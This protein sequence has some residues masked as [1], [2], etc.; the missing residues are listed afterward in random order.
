MTKVTGLPIRLCNARGIRVLSV[1]AQLSLALSATNC[2]TYASDRSAV[3]LPA[4][5]FDSLIEN[6]RI[7]TLPQDSSKGA[8]APLAGFTAGSRLVLLYGKSPSVR[9]FDASTGTLEVATGKPGDSPG[10]YRKPN[11]IAPWSNGGFVVYDDGRRRL[12]FRDSLGVLRSEVTVPEGSF[13]GLI[14]EP[15]LGHITLAGT[16]YYAKGETRSSYLHQLDSLGHLVRSFGQRESDMSLWK[17]A[18]STPFAQQLGDQIA[19][20]SMGSNVLT[21]YNGRTGTTHAFDVATGWYE[22]PVYPSDRML[23]RGASKQSASDQVRKFA[24]QHRMMS[25][26]FLLNNGRVLARFQGFDHAMHRFFYYA[27]VDRAGHTRSITLPTRAHVLA[28]RGDSVYWVSGGRDT[29]LH[30]GRGL[31]SQG[32]SDALTLH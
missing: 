11:G 30:F 20:G 23:T 28:T 24:I 18:F 29:P 2:T 21:Y 32:D 8:P 31:I 1:A 5:S 25:G 3:R 14:S 19:F 26:V 15:L 7:I 22:R 12:T 16:V 10:D 17:T 13:S 9:I 6:E 4:I 27:L